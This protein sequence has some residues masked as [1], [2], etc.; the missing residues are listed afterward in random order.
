MKIILWVHSGLTQ[1]FHTPSPGNIKPSGRPVRHNIRT[2]TSR[3]RPQLGSSIAPEIISD[4]RSVVPEVKPAN[5]WL[6]NPAPRKP[7]PSQK[8]TN[9][10]GKFDPNS[11][12]IRERYEKAES[13]MM[14]IIFGYIGI[15]ILMICPI[16]FLIFKVTKS[17]K[18]SRHGDDKDR[19]SLNDKLTRPD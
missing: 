17:D 2:P 4:P 13:N 14:K 3:H 12:E 18:N 15:A 11:Y 9:F 1:G 7:N 6:V 8:S 16:L 10:G 5:G 19:E